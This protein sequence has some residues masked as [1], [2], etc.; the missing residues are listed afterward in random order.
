LEVLVV[1]GII[2]VLFII[3]K[4]NAFFNKQN[5]RIDN[6]NE[7]ILIIENKNKKLEENKMSLGNFIENINNTLFEKSQ[8]QK[9]LAGMMADYLTIAETEYFKILNYSTRKRDRDRSFKIYELTGEIKRLINENKILWYELEY[10]KTLIPEVEDITEY[11]ELGRGMYEEGDYLRKFL[12]KEEYEKL[13]DKEKNERSLDYYLKRKKTNWEIGRDFERY[14]GYAFEKIGYVVEYYGIEKKLND[15]G[16]DL[17]AQNNE[18]IVIVQC[19]YWSRNKIIHEKHIAQ[20]YGTLVKY[21]LDNPQNRKSVKGIFIT[22]TKL[23]EEAL[24]F[25]AVLN[26][27]VLEERELGDYPLIKCNVN[28]DKDGN[29]TKIYHLPMDLQYDIVKIKPKEGDFYA[30]TIAE[31]EEAGF[32]RAYR[33]RGAS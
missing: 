28:R 17:I 32:R 23:S 29:I 13:S 31:A 26:I 24:R 33:W 3:F 9:W 10:I 11:D 4:I 12:P 8:S 27:E 5:S 21:K 22:H 7:K 6:L 18:N 15:L 30:F 16:R 1:I 25:A 2:F 20:L 14:V 19:K